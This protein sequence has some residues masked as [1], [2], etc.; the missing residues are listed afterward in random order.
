MN[1]L[2][3]SAHVVTSE[4]SLSGSNKS[5]DISRNSNTD[6]LPLF[7]SL[8]RS[9]MS[10][11]L[12]F[13]SAFWGRLILP[14]FFAKLKSFLTLNSTFCKCPIW[15]QKVVKSWWTKRLKHSVTYKC[16]KVLAIVAAAL[17]K[18]SM[19]DFYVVVRSSTLAIDG[20]SSGLLAIEPISA[21]VIEQTPN[22][23]SDLWLFQNQD[24]LRS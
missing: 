8:Q 18:P 23:C 7:S 12:L 2:W 17:V 9:A 19:K 22:G 13:I 6:T 3:E 21:D 15:K 11:S 1:R 20:K 14:P 4:N 5:A 24:C 16:P 10:M